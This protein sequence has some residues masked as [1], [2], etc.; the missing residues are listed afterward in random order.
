MLKKYLN[1]PVSECSNEEIYVAL[2]NF[3]KD[4]T[5]Q[6]GENK[7]DRKLYYISAEFL[8]GKLL[9]NNLINL[10]LYDDVKKFLSDSRAPFPIP[11]TFTLIPPSCCD[12]TLPFLLGTIISADV[13]SFPRSPTR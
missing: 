3:T 2:L 1:K 7:G 6:K 4:I 12:N 13:R 11:V 10:G 9:S 5:K 8:I